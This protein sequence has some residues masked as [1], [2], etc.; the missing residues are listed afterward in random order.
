[1]ARGSRNR[2]KES[3]SKKR[4]EQE[5]ELQDLEERVSSFSEVVD[6]FEDLPLSQPTKSALKNAHFV[7]CT[8]IQKKA[9][10]VALKGRDILGAAKTGSGKTLAFLIPVI[11]NL[12][13]R[14]WTP[15]DGLG[16]LIISPTREL[17]MQ[18]FET[19]VKIGRLHSF[20]AGLII[21][22]ND[23]KQERDRLSRMNILVCTPGRLLQHMDQAI[24]FDTSS[25]QMLVLDEADRILD[26]GFR[27]TLDAII[28]SLPKKRQTMLFSA[29]QTSVS[30]LARLS[31]HD[32]DY[33]S[34]HEH[35]DHVTPDNLN[36]FYLVAPLP[37]KLDILFGFI[38]THLK[39]KIIVFF[40]SCKQVRFA[41]ECFKRLRPGVPLM[42]LH[43]KQKQASRT[44]IAAK[45]TSTK[46][47]VLLCTDI[48]ARGL[49]FPAVDWVVQVDA[50]E[51]VQT[52][53]H[54]VGRTARFERG[55]NAL[56]M[57]LPSE[58]AFLKRLDSKKVPIERINIKE[59][60]K[61]SIRNNL[62]ALCFKD[63]DL[64]YLGQKAFI[65]YVRSV[66]LLKD[67]EVF[68][69]D[70]LPTA[71]F[72]D[73]LGLPGTPRIKFLENRKSNASIKKKEG[74]TALEASDEEESASDDEEEA[75][76][77]S[78]S[79]EE[80]EVNSS[81]RTIRSKVDRMFERKNQ[82]ILAEHREKL[83]ERSFSGAV[84][85]DS[86][87]DEDFMRLKRVSHDLDDEKKEKPFLIDSKRKEKVATHKKTLLKY[88]PNPEKLVFD[89]E[90]NAVPFYAVN[91][92]DTFLKDGA[93]A[94]QITSHLQKERE[95]LTQAD[96]QDKETVREKRRE[97]KRI[98]KEKERA[99]NGFA[100]DIDKDDL[101]SG[102]DS[103]AYESE[104]AEEEAVPVKKQKKWFQVDEPEVDRNI[105]ETEMPT[106]L[107][108]QEAL[109]LR[110]LEGA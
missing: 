40:S 106:T 43:G 66:F 92:E 3:R 94:E 56:L 5:Q 52:Y 79:S 78:E 104:G 65:S 45:F 110:L 39:L 10:Y 7:K 99:A 86:D 44:E 108:D 25:L 49:D 12:Y 22:G 97:K 4:Q 33:I 93:V 77:A 58:E 68:K 100:D 35:A 32:P 30:D 72:A 19:L 62:Q 63:P 53:I 75:S 83:L 31:L 64:K 91:N 67:K 24:N 42:H 60:K 8:D 1:M 98:R 47:A 46:N 9:I 84:A 36:Q 107:E 85:S 16:A 90:G 80:D 34:V 88:R 70:E 51:D 18:T 87:S 28:T 74:K 29:T 69:V 21:G 11:E 105:V 48:V 89:E 2:S 109:A 27:K 76:D 102:N 37:E 73:A 41:F 23:Y 38:K 96:L 50:P 81:K 95:A 26:M 103:A 20:S 61:T 15:Y 57:L 55:G 82:G 54:R 17:A 59:G 6:H 101:G 71:E 14:K 13:R